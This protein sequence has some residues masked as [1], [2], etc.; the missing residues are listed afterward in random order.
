M[1]YI[2]LELLKNACRAVISTHAARCAKQ[3][4]PL[5]RV[6]VIVVH[7]DEDVTIKISDRGRI[8]LLPRQ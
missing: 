7:G 5:P 6:H 2:L 1:H 8:P 4:V 3:G